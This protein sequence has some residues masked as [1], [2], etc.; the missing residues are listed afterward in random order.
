MCKRNIE[1]DIFGMFPTFERYLP[2]NETE[3][4]WAPCRNCVLCILKIQISQNFNWLDAFDVNI[5]SRLMVFEQ[6]QTVAISCEVSL[7]DTFNAE[8]ILKF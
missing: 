6:E 3:T 2:S 1:R 7:K 5:V 4:N 8:I